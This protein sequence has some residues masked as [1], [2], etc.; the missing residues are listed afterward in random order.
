MANVLVLGATGQIGI[1]LTTASLA[2]GHNVTSV[3]RSSI[4][5]KPAHMRNMFSEVPLTHRCLDIFEPAN[6]KTLLDL[7]SQH[8]IVFHAA[9][10]YTFKRADVSQAI[11]NNSRLISTAVKAGFTTSSN[12]G[13][14]FVRIGS[15]PVETDPD[16]NPLSK[17]PY[18]GIP[19]FDAKWAMSCNALNAHCSDGASILSAAYPA[20]FGFGSDHGRLEALARFITGEYPFIP[21]ITTNAAPAMHLARGALLVAKKGKPGKTYQLAGMDIDTAEIIK[22]AKRCAGVKGIRRLTPTISISPT[23]MHGAVMA[24]RG[25][26]R[27]DLPPELNVTSFAL[28]ASMGSRSYYAA[29]KEIGYKP[30]TMTDLFDAISAQVLW[31]QDAGIIK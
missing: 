19:Y 14:R 31:Y 7:F 24:L 3:A 1:A 2:D 16:G 29:V 6:Q 25:L 21:S 27:W 28:L 22:Y 12:N 4:D 17:N 23:L 5:K 15:S 11:K 20:V 9:E 10:P 30:P 8:E 26:L 18:P 13:K